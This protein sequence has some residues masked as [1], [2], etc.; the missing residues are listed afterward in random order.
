MLFLFY[1]RAFP[2]FGDE[3]TMDYDMLD[4]ENINEDDSSSHSDGDRFNM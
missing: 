4:D 3:S 2:A 1:L